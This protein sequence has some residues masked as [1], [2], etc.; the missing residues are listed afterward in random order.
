MEISHVVL[1]SGAIGRAVMQQLILQGERVRMVNR[2]GV[3]DEL[4]SGVELVKADLFDPAAV[5]AVCRGA[6][7]VYQA[8]QPVYTKWPELFPPLQKSI[9]DGLS[10]SKSKLVIADNMYLYGPSG[11]QPMTE[12][13]PANTVT[14][15]GMTRRQMSLDALDAHRAGRVRVAIGRGSDYFGPWGRNSAVMGQRTFYPL[16]TDRPAQ[17]LGDPELPHT[18]TYVRDFG[19]ALVLLGERDKSDGEVWHVPNDRPT[20]TQSEMVKMV[21]RSLGVKAKQYANGK[22]MMVLAGLLLPQA[23]EMVEMMYQFSLP[24]VV[25]SGKFERAFEV[26]ATPMDQAIEETIAWYSDHPPLS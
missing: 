6:A 16:L 17:L 15:K 7:V 13:T 1:G 2:S 3:M 21:A 23:K 20:L 24:F 22:M 5:R 8:A 11:A 14:R 26:R 9:L 12:S 18:V 10:G 4:P 25:D 19:K